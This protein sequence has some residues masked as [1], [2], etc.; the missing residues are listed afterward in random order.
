MGQQQLLLLVLVIV[1]VGAAVVSGIALFDQSHEQANRDLILH[2]GLRIVQDLQAWKATPAHYGGGAEASGFASVTFA[3][4]G[5]HQGTEV[6]AGSF[7]RLF[8]HADVAGCYVLSTEWEGVPPDGFTLAMFDASGPCEPGRLDLTEL[9]ALASVS[10]P[11]P[12]DI[13]LDFGSDALT[14]LPS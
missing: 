4:I 10:G 2:E 12:D 9:V 13:R 8:T 6:V 5:R 3:D 7:G 14:G 1:V 11:A